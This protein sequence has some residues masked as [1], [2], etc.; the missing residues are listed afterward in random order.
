MEPPPLVESL[1]RVEVHVSVGRRNAALLVV[2]DLRWDDCGIGRCWCCWAWRLRLAARLRGRRG[3][4]PM[5]VLGWFGKATGR[6]SSSLCGSRSGNERLHVA[7]TS[8][9]CERLGLSRW[10]CS[11]SRPYDPGRSHPTARTSSAYHV[12]RRLPP[13]RGRQAGG[14]R[15]SSWR[16]GDSAREKALG[17]RWSSS[18]RGG[19]ICP[20]IRA[21]RSRLA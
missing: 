21:S 2:S 7:R 4:G 16:S 6:C 18:A 11:Y 1:A 19:L 9:A 5:R 20:T 3:S 12:V 17:E 15:F 10:I 14:S 13:T 8:G